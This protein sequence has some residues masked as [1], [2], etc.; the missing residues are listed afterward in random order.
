MK[1]AFIFAHPDDEAYG[2]AGTIA[3]L[4]Q[5]HEVTVVS[6]C[7]GDR[8]G[9]E[10]VA[11]NRQEA[12]VNSCAV[13]GAR[14]VMLEFSDCKLEYASTLSAVEELI[15]NLAP[16]VVYTHNISDLHVDHRLV[17]EACL[18]ACRPKPQSTVKELYYSEIPASTEWTFGQLD[19][20]FI[21]NMYV[22][23]S[24]YISKKL[25]AISH[26]STEVYEYPDARSIESIQTL[27]KYRGRQIGVHH[28]EAFKLV[29][30]RH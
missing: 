30:A 28:G 29:F 17:A 20:Q 12:F 21:P 7:Q 10:E 14:L 4:S 18:V 25:Q 19:P 23:V 22:D 8:P 15:E 26:Y 9:A 27:A 24:D 2:P 13:L 16:D 5:D 6:L 3:K 11:V 1:I